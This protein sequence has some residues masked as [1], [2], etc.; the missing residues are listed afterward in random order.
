MTRQI[1]TDSEFLTWLYRKT[2]VG[3]FETV[4]LTANEP[5]AE[6]LK[7]PNP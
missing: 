7:L 3:V 5:R 1:L 2:I 4:A 6:V